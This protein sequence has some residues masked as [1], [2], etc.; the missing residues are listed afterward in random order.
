VNGS[1]AK[2]LLRTEKGYELVLVD[3]TR[4]V[5]TAERGE[6]IIRDVMPGMWKWQAGP[7][8]KVIAVVA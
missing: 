2:C 3:D 8:T 4:I 1:S 7:D 6:M 5:F